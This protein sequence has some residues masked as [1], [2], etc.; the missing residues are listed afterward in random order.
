M[1]KSHTNLPK[2][3]YVNGTESMLD[4]VKVMWEALN[5]YM[6]KHSTYFKDDFRGMTFLKRK[7]TYEEGCPGTNAC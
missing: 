3:K 6:G 1:T 5:H 4:E 7:I 2:I